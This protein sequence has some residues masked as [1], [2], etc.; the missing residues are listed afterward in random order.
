MERILRK[1]M[2]IVTST[3]NNFESLASQN[4]INLY[5][6]LIKNAILLSKTDTIHLKISHIRNFL[7]HKANKLTNQDIKYMLSDLSSRSM[8]INY[9][10]TVSQ[11]NKQALEKEYVPFFSKIS[12]A[13]KDVYFKVNEAI[14]EYIDFKQQDQYVTTLLSITQKAKSKYTPKFFEFV[15][16]FASF[17]GTR[18]NSI[19]ISLSTLRKVFN[20]NNKY[21]SYSDINR[22]VF[23]KVQKECAEFGLI[24]SYNPYKGTLKDDTNRRYVG[25]EI[26]MTDNDKKAFQKKLNSLKSKN[27]LQSEKYLE[28][29]KILQFVRKEA[30]QHT[31]DY[32]IS[33]LMCQADFYTHVKSIT[34]G[35]RYGTYIFTFR[36]KKTIAGEDL[37]KITA[38]DDLDT[39]LEYFTRKGSD[40]LEENHL[41]QCILNE[42]RD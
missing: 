19:K 7:G 31:I 9:F 15:S 23:Q 16:S 29:D 42:K 28:Q 34:A 30:K 41:I 4:I 17:T 14:F 25:I 13:D 11:Q 5:L 35:D 27:F 39:I 38:F 2:R 8:K 20:L 1:D 32:L 22:Y 10:Q 24:F 12:V 40:D 26:S 3:L 21:P 18:N 33:Q 6:Y 36:N 37:Y